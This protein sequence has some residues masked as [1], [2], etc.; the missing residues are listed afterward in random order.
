MKQRDAYR[1][2]QSVLATLQC[3]PEVVETNSESSWQE[4]IALRSE[5][6]AHFAP[7]V[8][9]EIPVI[10]ACQA[11]THRQLSVQDVMTEA[12]RL[13]RVAPCERRWQQLHLLLQ[14]AGRG[15]PP[16]PMTGMEASVTPPLVKRIRVRD[17][18]EWAARHGLLERLFHFFRALPE[19]QWVHMG[20]SRGS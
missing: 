10:D 16:P 17:Q 3:L 4:F 7:T 12:R 18:V 8:T 19:D 5:N 15:T 1:N 9:S 14:G 13:N 11:R 2:T 20:H 6:Q